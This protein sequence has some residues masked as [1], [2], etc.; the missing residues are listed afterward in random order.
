MTL[1][2]I[3]N[4]RILHPK[5]ADEKGFI[6]FMPIPG[7]LLLCCLFPKCSSY[8]AE[9]SSLVL[10]CLLQIAV[11][12]SQHSE[13]KNLLKNQ[14]QTGYSFECCDLSNNLITVLLD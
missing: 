13:P 5:T 12:C 6:F 4:P 2:A 9:N 10:K 8:F 7:L 14:M 3:A 11:A 1:Q